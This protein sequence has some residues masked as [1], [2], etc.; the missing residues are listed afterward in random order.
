[1]AVSR[2]ETWDAMH[3]QHDDV[4]E[5]YAG[6]SQCAAYCYDEV[7][8]E[9]EAALGRRPRVWHWGCGTSTLGVTLAERHGCDVDNSD[10]S[11]PAIARMASKYPAHRWR[12]EDARSSPRESGSGGP[13][14][15]AVDKGVFDS[16]T[17]SRETRAA[18]AAAVVARVHEALA[19]GA[20]WVCF[21]GF[22]PDE[23]NMRCMIE[24]SAPWES[25]DCDPFG[26]A[27]LEIPGQD[28]LYVYV[29]RRRPS[30]ASI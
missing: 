2:V 10:A 14:D 1:M 29:C 20:A 25:V 27:P 4:R 17:A 22:A 23:K 8:A 30:E 12:V 9:A 26:D 19:P 11:A 3:E 28:S 6:A 7:L 13:Y 18:A 16:I 21:S 24:E 5:W 15:L